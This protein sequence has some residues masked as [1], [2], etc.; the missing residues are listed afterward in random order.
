M[1]DQFGTTGVAHRCR[2]DPQPPQHPADRGGSHPVTEFAQLPLNSL[3]SPAWVLPSH[4]RDQRGHHRVLDR[5]TPDTVRIGPLV[6]HQATMPTHD[7]ARRDQSMH[8]QH[9]RHL[10]TSAAN[11]ARSAQSRRGLELVLRST[12]TS[13]RSTRSSTSL[14]ADERPSNINR[15]SRCKK[16]R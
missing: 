11:S 3:V 2:R 4:A 16:I 1:D 10:R 7:R 14:D 13:W 9:R 12:A 6:G 8:P 15:F 5:W